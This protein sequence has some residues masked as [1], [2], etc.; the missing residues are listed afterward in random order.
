MLFLVWQLAGL[1]FPVEQLFQPQQDSPESQELLPLLSVPEHQ[2]PLLPS[3][4]QP[5]RAPV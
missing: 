4:V 5:R 1:W 2:Q 3:K